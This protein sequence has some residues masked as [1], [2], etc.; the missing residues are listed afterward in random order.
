MRISIT[1]TMSQPQPSSLPYWRT[2]AVE[3]SFPHALKEAAEEIDNLKDLLGRRIDLWSALRFGGL[4][5]AYLLGVLTCVLASCTAIGH[6]KVDGWP[7]LEVREHHVP[8]AE[9][10]DRCAKYA[11]WGSAP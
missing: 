1:S 3:T 2:R 10:R 6:Q 11:P 5:V 4:I 7:K 8:H 9:M